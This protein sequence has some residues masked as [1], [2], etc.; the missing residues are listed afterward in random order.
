MSRSK[1]TL[2]RNDDAPIIPANTEPGR[3]PSSMTLRRQEMR[4]M[5][6]IYRTEDRLLEQVDDPERDRLA[7]AT[8]RDLILAPDASDSAKRDAVRLLELVNTRLDNRG[9]ALTRNNTDR[10]RVKASVAAATVRTWQPNGRQPE[11]DPELQALIDG[12]GVEG[13]DAGQPES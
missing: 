3:V 6:R 13:D 4:L 1:H 9:I 5:L 10:L 8:C 7:L 12:A 11:P 2:P